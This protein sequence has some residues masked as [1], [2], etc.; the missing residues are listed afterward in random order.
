LPAALTRESNNGYRFAKEAQQEFEMIA[1]S[2]ERKTIR[3][4]RGCVVLDNGLKVRRLEIKLSCNA[5]PFP[6]DYS[7]M[8]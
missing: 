7:N 5:N 2:V 4:S 3:A 1:E 8:D 6:W